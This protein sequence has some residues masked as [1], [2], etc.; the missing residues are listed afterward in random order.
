MWLH[1]ATALSA[2]LTA[3]C[4]SDVTVSDAPASQPV[5]PA[6]AL[7]CYLALDGQ[8]RGAETAEGEV[9]GACRCEGEVF[10]VRTDAQLASAMQTGGCIQL[11]AGSYG[12]VDVPPGV[13]LVGASVGAV[14]FQRLELQGDASVC[15]ATVAAGVGVDGVGAELKYVAVDGGAGDGVLVRA[16]S[17]LRLVG[18]TVTHAVRYAVSAFDAVR[19]EVIDSRIEANAGPG[20]W[21]QCASGCDCN[22]S[23]DLVVHNTLIRD[24]ALIGMSIVG[25]NA[26]L[27]RL[28]I[29][30][31]TGGA[32]FQNGGGIAASGCSVV[33]A[34]NVR[35][36]SNA[37]YGILMSQAGGAM[38]CVHVAG[39]LRGIW[40]Q[41]SPN[42]PMPDGALRRATVENN[43]GVGIGLGCRVAPPS[44]GAITVEN[45]S[46]A[47]THNI[48]L[49]VLIN[50]VSAGTELVGDGI[51]WDGGIEGH[52]SDI[53]IVNSDRA[54]VLIDG[55]AIGTLHNV[56][57][58]SGRIVQ[59]NYASGPQPTVSG[60][61]PPIETSP[62]S[63]DAFPAPECIVEP[64]AE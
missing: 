34:D 8:I 54:G 30:T 55:P 42:E 47:D 19:L 50:G 62:P 36:E 14:H 37:D 43:D 12:D 16:G 23:S 52:F 6:D 44:S 18:S 32:N 53:A 29:D 63:D 4:A 48:P 27:S 11:A 31:T 64:A 38:D 3:S 1:R 13:Q 17:G 21:M 20:L 41:G 24:N 57:P 5:V 9:S 61:T 45:S 25:T 2:L 60:G 59:T 40:F 51:H 28:Q 26:V 56:I 22:H 39:N 46:V 33:A 15:R 49:P 35:V 58:D 7:G 10:G